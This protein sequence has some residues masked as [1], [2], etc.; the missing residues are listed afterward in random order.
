M[1][2]C[3]LSDAFPEVNT[4]ARKEDKK[5]AKRCKG[6]PLSFLEPG[7]QPV[8]D[9]DRPALRPKSDVPPINKETGVREHAPVDSEPLKESWMDEPSAQLVALPSVSKGLSGTN[10]KPKY[11]GANFDDSVEEGFASFTNVIGDDPAYNL[12][13]D[14]KGVAKASGL[15]TP[16]VVDVWKPLTPTGTTTAYFNKLPPPGGIVTAEEAPISSQKEEFFRKLD[17]IYAR[18]DELESRRSENS[19][20][21]VLLFIMS[22]IFVLFSM[23]IL[24]RKTGNVRIMTK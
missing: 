15:P 18:L 7:D 24:V 2:Y 3:S 1:E 23:D 17:R 9:P 11:F 22:G 10:R 16:S 20:T 12:G 14:G 5:K 13:F 8:V 21:E 4:V 6:P 19:Q